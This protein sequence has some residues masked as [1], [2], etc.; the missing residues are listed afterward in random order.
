MTTHLHRRPHRAADRRSLQ[1]FMS[2]RRQVLRDYQAFSAAS[3]K[4]SQ[5][6]AESVDTMKKMS[7]PDERQNKSKK[8]YHGRC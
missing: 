1:R 8:R 3:R 2:E 7:M 4:H 6:M 5:P